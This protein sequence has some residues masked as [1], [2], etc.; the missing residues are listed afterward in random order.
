MRKIYFDACCIN[1]LTDDQAQ[2]RIRKGADAIETPLSL[3]SS[4]SLVWAGGNILELEI[5]RNP[6]PERRN[7]A[8]AML[9]FSSEPVNPGEIIRSRS[10]ALHALGYGA[11][12]ALHLAC[13][14]QARVDVFLTTDDRLLRKAHRKIGSPTIRVENPVSLVQE[15]NQRDTSRDE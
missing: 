12:D 14:E 7:D 11:F 9:R 13:A 6:D 5:K 10:R 1:R 8:A 3:V 2:E 15:W 4:G